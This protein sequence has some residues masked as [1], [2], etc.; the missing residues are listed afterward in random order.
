[1]T[2]SDRL[3]E[4]LAE[5]PAEVRA[6]LQQAFDQVAGE[7]SPALVLFGAGLLGQR[8]L[9]ILRTIGI[10]P[11]AFTDNNKT[12]WGGVVDGLKVLAPR[13]AVETLREKAVF[14]VTVYNGSAVRRQL[15]EM[16]CGRVAAFT[17]LFWKYPDAFLPFGGMSAPEPIF[18]E[19]EA[20]RA[21]LHL[22]AD[23]QSRVN[24]VSQ[25]RWQFHLD[26]EELPKPCPA[27]D[28]YFPD[29]L[30]VPREDEVFVDC[31]A[32][33]GDSVRAFIARRRGVFK[34]AVAL[35]P[36]PQN[37][38][39]LLRY[40]QGAEPGLRE[41]LV[42]RPLAAASHNGVLSF[43]VH[44]DMSSTA[45]S[46]GTVTLDCAR[47]DDVLADYPPTYIKMDIEGAELDALEGARNVIAAHRPV[48]AICAYHKKND[49]WEIPQKIKSL[50]ADY[51]VFLRLYAEDCW[52]LVCYAVPPERLARPVS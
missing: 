9:R 42:P 24:Y 51:K 41:R 20:V 30:V 43:D 12:L 19:K 39:G 29:D 36:D 15:R 4:V 37:F 17:T 27:Q 25:L 14:V 5:S 49:L 13:E 35:E 21:G 52:E 18:Q 47:L 11:L 1:M 6:R 28:T 45:T 48:L 38:A 40:V 31:G 16:G 50:C 32:Y 2:A 8:T 23:E 34:T 22:W 33:D 44:G 46:T 7:P 3:E 10:E 26:T